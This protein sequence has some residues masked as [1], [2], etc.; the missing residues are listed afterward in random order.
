M[1]LNT[2]EKKMLAIHL[3]GIIERMETLSGQLMDEYY[4]EST[5]LF[6]SDVLLA[7]HEL[8]DLVDKMSKKL[9]HFNPYDDE[10]LE[11]ILF[12]KQI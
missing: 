1:I 4:R 8:K 2:Y 10:L 9:H 3:S 6:I 11:A 7:K 5:D 12:D